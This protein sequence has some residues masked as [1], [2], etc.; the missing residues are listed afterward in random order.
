[1]PIL[2]P[3]L[4]IKPKYLYFIFECLDLFIS[5][6]DDL[7]QFRHIQ[8]YCLPVKKCKCINNIQE[9]QKTIFTEDFRLPFSCHQVSFA[10]YLFLIQ[11][12]SFIF[13]AAWFSLRIWQCSHRVTQF[14]PCNI[15]L[16]SAWTIPL[17]LC[18][19][20]FL[21]SLFGWN[22]QVDSRILRWFNSSRRSMFLLSSCLPHFDR[23][24]LRI[25]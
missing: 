21:S 23:I 7:M 17:R 10:I 16:S 13:P 24:F 11:V 4:K 19:P 22:S 14:A 18:F 6:F 15:L 1:M 2:P 3:L 5:I 20:S 9:N 8:F 12:V 25:Y